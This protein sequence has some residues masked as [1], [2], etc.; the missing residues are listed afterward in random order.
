[1]RLPK[2]ERRLPTVLEVHEVERLLQQPDL[3]EPIGLRDRAILET[4]YSA[5]LRIIDISDVANPTELGDYDTPGNARDVTA[6]GNYAYVADEYQG[7]RIIDVSDPA[8]P[9]QVGLY[10]TL[11][12]AYGV[13]VAGG[14]AYV[15]DGSG[16]LVILRFHSGPTYRVYLPLVLH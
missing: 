11:G 8:H 15:A 16:G 4:I 12:E 2:R 1:M 5:G 3:S 9:V 7:L 14:Y 13:A 10:D 6:T